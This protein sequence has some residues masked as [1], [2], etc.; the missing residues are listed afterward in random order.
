MKKSRVL[1]VDDE[2]DLLEI[3]TG[4]FEEEAIQIDTCSDIQRALLLHKKNHYDVIISDAQMPSGSG[5]EL[6]RVL[7]KELGLRV[8]LILVT[9][10]LQAHDLQEDRFDVVLYKPLRFE[11][12]IEKVKSLLDSP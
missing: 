3:A 10:D 7:R 1:Y 5:Y 12:L 4:L 6:F 11:E 2:L 9:G 8:K